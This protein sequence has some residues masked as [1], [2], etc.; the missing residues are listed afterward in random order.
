MRPSKKSF[1]QLSVL[2][3]IVV[4][5]FLFGYLAEDKK[6]ISNIHKIAPKIASADSVIGKI[7]GWA[8]ADK[9]GWISFSSKNSEV[10][11]P[12]DYEVS[13]KPSG[14]LEGYAW[15]DHIG[16]IGFNES[17]LADCPQGKCKAYFENGELKGWVKAIAGEDSNDGWDGWIH[18][19]GDHHNIELE[20]NDTFKGYAWGDDVVG[21]IDF[22]NVELDK[23]NPSADI[24]A[25]PNSVKAGESV[26]ISWECLNSS[27]VVGGC[28][29]DSNCV[30]SPSVLSGD[31][32]T[33]DL[34]T[35][36][37]YYITCSN[38]FDDSDN[39]SVQVSVI[40]PDLEISADPEK[41]RG[42]S[43]ENTTLISWSADNV[44]SNTCEVTGPNGLLGT[45]ESGSKETAPI[46]GESIYTLSCE[47]ENGFVATESVTVELIPEWEEF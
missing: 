47:N 26:T 35:T 16:W 43:G 3:G 14:V 41:V 40:V 13:V 25:A 22:N 37:S 31:H 10:T 19:S 32:D 44:V 29:G 46:T 33:I 2:I 45:G 38:I 6:N 17:D 7:T 18:L 28:S 34:S 9:I 15:S 36:T 24:N 5:L 30:F 20:A 11:E 27:G 39:D 42:S 8:W 21:W 23:E 1:Y 4:F 12:F